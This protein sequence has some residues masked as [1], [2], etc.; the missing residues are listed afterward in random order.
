MHQQCS[1]RLSVDPQS[2]Q[3]SH[4]A[5][6]ER[7]RVGVCVEEGGRPIV[8]KQILGRV[9]TYCVCIFEVSL[10][11]SFSMAKKSFSA[12]FSR[13]R[14]SSCDGGHR[15][16][17][18]VKKGHKMCSELRLDSQLN[19]VLYTQMMAPSNQGR[20]IQNIEQ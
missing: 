11:D 3:F 10:S 5:D 8:A 6:Q 1:A 20:A 7:W 4:K 12:R 13:S 9:G 15:N 14:S 18:T 16:T 2:T 19:I 17:Q